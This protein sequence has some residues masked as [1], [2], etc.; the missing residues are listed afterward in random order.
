MIASG[1]SW[2]TLIPGVQDDTLM[3]IPTYWAEGQDGFNQVLLHAILACV[4]LIGLA[5]LGRLGLESAKRKQGIERY[6]AD[7]RLN[8]RTLSELFVSAIRSMMSDHLGSKDVKTYFPLI[9]GLFIYIFTCNI[10]GIFPGFLP[11]TDNINTN[12]GMAIIAFLVFNFV[13]L[14]RDPVNYIKHILGPV[15]WLI[16]LMLIVESVSL[17]ARPITL[18]VRLTANMFGDHTVFSVM[19]DLVP[20]VLPSALLALA[21]VVC[22]IQAFIFSILTTVYISLAVPHHEHHEH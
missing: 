16:P 14:S 13:G 6:F 20:L 18:G 4:L 7:D 21:I 17:V 9:A 3:S 12:W 22:T 19:S 2:M 15:W 11:P 8:M 1:F 5:I 10:M